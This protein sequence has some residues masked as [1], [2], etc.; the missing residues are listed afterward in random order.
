MLCK[1]VTNL[2]AVIKPE[3]VLHGVSIYLHKGEILESV[4]ERALANFFIRDL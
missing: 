1:N 4:I 3:A 2:P